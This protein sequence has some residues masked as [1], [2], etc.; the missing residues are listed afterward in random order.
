M[1]A[2]LGS[3]SLY[4]ASVRTLPRGPQQPGREVTRSGPQ[5]LG[6]EGLCTLAAEGL[7]AAAA[8]QE[9]LGTSRADWR[10]E[11]LTTLGTLSTLDAAAGPQSRPGWRRHV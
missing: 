3:G 2:L 5:D 8:T 1:R 4:F 11:D 6:R 9:G 7:A 10:A